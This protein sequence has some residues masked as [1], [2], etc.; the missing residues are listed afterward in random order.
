MGA[1]ITGLIQGLPGFGGGSDKELYGSRPVV[2]KSP[3]YA[4]GLQN[5]IN[6]DIALLPSLNELGR[7][8]TDELQN[9]LEHALPGYTGLRDATTGIISDKLAG[10]IPRDV[11]QMLERNAA[12]KGIT[13]GTSGSNFNQYDELRNLGLTSLGVQNEGLQQANQWLNLNR[14]NVFD[15][16]K[17]FRT[18][19]DS[20]KE[21]DFKWSRDW[22]ANQVAAAP[23]PQKR[24]AWDTEMG[25]IGE[26]LSIYGGGAGYQQTYR[27]GY[28]GGGSSFG[29]G[30]GS[31]SG[32]G[33]QGFSSYFGGGPQADF[34]EGQTS[35]AEY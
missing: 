12:E 10:K 20:A 18:K 28:G 32:G 22:L 15:F 3:D 34:G 16:S 14:S 25:F 17:M 29:S 19:E 27:P 35:G 11:Q 8:S 6:Q 23:D 13:M 9:L 7:L 2:P 4:A 26:I 21:L 31:G 1:G 24:G 30:G 5:T 33:P